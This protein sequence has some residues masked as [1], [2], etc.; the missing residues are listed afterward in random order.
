VVNDI[1]AFEDT[2]TKS[3]AD[4]HFAANGVIEKSRELVAQGAD[5]IVVGCCGIGPFCSA[6]GL[7]K[8]EVDGR[9]IPILDAQ[10]IAVKT[11]EMAVDIKKGTG[12]PFTSLPR[13]AAEDMKRVRD[14]FGLPT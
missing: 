12:L 6:A 8:I 9:N 3:F 10:M 4:P 14:I 5:V 2:W 1:H 7:H 13:P 11:A